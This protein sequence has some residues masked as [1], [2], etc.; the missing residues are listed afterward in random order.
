MSNMRRALLLTALGC[1]LAGCGGN[2]GGV[3]ALTT[4]EAQVR[5]GWEKTY[6]VIGFFTPNG[7]A[8]TVCN[9]TLTDKCTNRTGT[10]ITS[11]RT[12]QLTVNGTTNTYLTTLV[13]NQAADGSITLLNVTVG[14]N[15]TLTVQST[16]FTVPGTWSTTTTATGT[17]TFTD[18]SVA[19]ESLVVS[20]STQIQTQVG[21]IDAWTTAYQ[22]TYQ[23]NLDMNLTEYYV[24]G[25]AGYAYATGTLV[26][27]DGTFTGTFDLQQTNAPLP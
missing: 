3:G 20:G 10:Q 19:T 22:H 25:I 13:S 15:P 14:A 16:T 27:S 11:T 5:Q 8:A 2:S 24:P 1:C 26:L 12:L 18:S 9:G 21:A 6:N 23:G 7:G 17:T 4:Q